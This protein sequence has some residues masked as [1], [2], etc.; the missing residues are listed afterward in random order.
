MGGCGCDGSLKIGERQSKRCIE[1]Q[2]IDGR[3]LKSNHQRFDCQTRLDGAKM[4]QNKIIQGCNYVR[5][6]EP[7]YGTPLDPDNNLGTCLGM[8]LTV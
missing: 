6:E 8:R 3:N 1:H 4:P 7:A 2:A 5:G